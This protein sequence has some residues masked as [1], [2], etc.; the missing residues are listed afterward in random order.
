MKNKKIYTAFI[1]LFAI[2][3]LVLQVSMVQFF[4]DHQGTDD[5]SVELI[6][7]ISPNYKPWF[8]NIW[9]PQNDFTEKLIFFIQASLGVGII[10]FYVLKQRRN[11]NKQQK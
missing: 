11:A 8:S 5:K 2:F 1:F 9:K 3:I 4:P 10:V 7:K 6:L